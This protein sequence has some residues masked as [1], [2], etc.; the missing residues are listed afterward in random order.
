M[1]L[2]SEFATGHLFRGFKNMSTNCLIFF[3]SGGGLSAP[4]EYGLVLATCFQR[5]ECSRSKGVWLSKVDHKK[6]I[7]SSVLFSPSLWL[8][9]CHEASR[10][11]RPVAA[12]NWVLQQ[13][14]EWGFLESALPAPVRSSDDCSL[15]HH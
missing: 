2:F 14:C 4:L 13:L 12:K 5:I 3:L 11:W 15:S 1:Y 9:G 10:L 6:S 8:W 7:V